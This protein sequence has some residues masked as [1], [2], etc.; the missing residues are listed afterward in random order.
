MSAGRLRDVRRLG[1]Q[2]LNVLSDSCFRHQFFPIVARAGQCGSLPV[3]IAGA[4]NDYELRNNVAAVCKTHEGLHLSRRRPTHREC[5]LLL[6]REI[7]NEEIGVR[8]DGNIYDLKSA[9]AVFS[10]QLAHQVRRRLAVWAGRLNKLQRNYLAAVLGERLLPVTRHDERQLRRLPYI[11]QTVG[12][13]QA[14][15]CEGHKASGNNRLIQRW[16]PLRRF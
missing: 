14:G 3:D 13:K 11:F 4:V 1:K 7:V 16:N 6:F 12:P 5:D 2:L 10:L 15:A 9:I 8:V